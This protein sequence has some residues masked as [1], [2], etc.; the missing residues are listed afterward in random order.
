MKSF[1]KYSLC[2]APLLFFVGALFSAIAPS[3]KPVTVEQLQDYKTLLPWKPEDIAAF[4]VNAE[5]K[6]GTLK[7]DS[8]V[9]LDQPPKDK[10]AAKNAKELEKFKA[11]CARK[12]TV[13]FKVMVGIDLVQ[14]KD[15][16]KI[17]FLKGKSEIYVLNE[18]DKK[19]SLKDKV[20]NAKLCPT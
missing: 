3:K 11:K 20:D 12:G 17:K 6:D 16:K 14:K 18:T 9:V 19:V 4:Q 2:V 10:D 1:F 8:H 13:P 15:N 5:S 7:L